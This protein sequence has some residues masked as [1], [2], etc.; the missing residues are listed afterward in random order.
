[1]T[2]QTELDPTRLGAAELARRIAE[3]Q[4]TA[5]E[6]VD[7]HIARIESVQPLLNAMTATRFERAR[8]EAAA[9]DLR[10]A[11]AEPLGPLHGVPITIKDSLD[12]AGLPSTFGL[13]SRAGILAEADEEHVAALRRAGA[14]V[15]GKTNV[16]QILLFF[17]SDNP[18]HGRTNNPWDLSRTPGGSSGGEAAVIAAGGSPLGLGTDIGGS[19]RL[20]ASFTGIASIRPTAGRLVDP[21]RLSVPVGEQAIVSQV[22]VFA[23]FVPDV[24]LGLAVANTVNVEPELGLADYADVEPAS[25]RIGYYID[26]GIVPASTAIVRA[27]DEA[28][29][30]LAAAG[31]EVVPFSPPDL[32]EA[33]RIYLGIVTA[34]GGAG[35]R[36]T[37]GS[38]PVDPRLA[39]LTR[40]SG[41]PAPARAAAGALLRMTGQRTLGVILAGLGHTRTRQYWDLLEQQHDYRRRWAA[42]MDE[43]GIDAVL[44]P[45]CAVPAMGHGAGA[46][47]SMPGVYSLVN[48]V[49]GYPA[50]VVP[51]T[52]VR[53]DEQDRRPP[54]KDRVLSA[55]RRVD[56]ESAG[57]PICVQVAARPWRDHVALA[58]MHAIQQRALA[59]PGYPHR[60]PPLDGG[61]SH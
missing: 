42:A 28:K 59:M 34:D 38:D 47:L 46:D 57:L 17:E 5:V 49:L 24:A 39:P 35:I 32:A 19:G 53:P 25:L 61:R 6:V 33:A 14:I 41:L 60:I 1:M 21:G 58:V 31:A 20:P 11:A 22:T 40:L 44:S 56:R 52:T 26:D 3:G 15:L 55:A 50:G 12:V 10:Q 43:A 18:L 37:L 7:A 30:L 45:V 51:V 23:R 54:T 27:V 8:A 2:M 16:A 29:N 36:R 4:L 48:N 9:A 13:P